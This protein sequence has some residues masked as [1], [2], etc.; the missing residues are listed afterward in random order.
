M[1]LISNLS[2]VEGAFVTL[3]LLGTY[4]LIGTIA[5]VYLLVKKKEIFKLFPCYTYLPTSKKLGAFFTQP[6]LIVAM[7]IMGIL[8][9]AFFAI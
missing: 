2:E 4:V 5:L 1:F 9:L 6:V 8:C 3:A 7:G